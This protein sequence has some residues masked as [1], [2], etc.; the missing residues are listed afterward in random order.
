M[1]ESRI[2]TKMATNLSC[3]CYLTRNTTLY[4]L[5]YVHQTAARPAE[6]QQAMSQLLNHHSSQWSYVPC[7]II[8]INAGVASR[9]SMFQHVPARSSTPERSVH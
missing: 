9:C 2:L 1:S 3:E 6:T 7:V 8:K 4:P 5:R